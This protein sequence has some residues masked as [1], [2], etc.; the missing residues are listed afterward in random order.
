MD[1]LSCTTSTLNHFIEITKGDCYTGTE[2][3]SGYQIQNDTEEYND[4]LA[5][6]EYIKIDPKYT[7]ILVLTTHFSN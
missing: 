7:E 2:V 6:K 1:L 3:L 5:A 4:M